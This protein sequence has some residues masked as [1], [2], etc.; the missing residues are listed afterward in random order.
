MNQVQPWVERQLATLR[1]GTGQRVQALDVTDDRLADVLRTLSDDTCWTNFERRLSGTLLRVYDLRP[2]RVR[3]DSTTASGYWQVTDDGLFQFGHSKDRRPDL[4]QLKVM[5][6]TLDPLGLPIATEVLSGERADDPLYLP[7]I[8]RLRASLPQRGLLYV[9]ECKLGAL[10]RARHPPCAVAG[11][12][13]QISV[14][15][16]SPTSRPCRNRAGADAK[17]HSAIAVSGCPALSG[18]PY[19]G[20]SSV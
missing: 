5:L 4:P 10:G 20:I 13:G 15:Q 17:V 2:E 1:I 16:R 14:Q 8:A 11:G 19:T 3:L 12:H 7:A 9:G 6:A 18:Y